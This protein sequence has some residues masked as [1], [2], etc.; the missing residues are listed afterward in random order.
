M[1]QTLTVNVI[2]SA[3]GGY[4]DAIGTQALPRILPPS[5]MWYG[6]LSQVSQSD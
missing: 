5:G 2:D 3:V 1:S 6:R 4:Q